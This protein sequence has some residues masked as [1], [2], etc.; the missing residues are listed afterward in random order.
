[1]NLPTKAVKQV[2]M[3]AAS[4][5]RVRLALSLSVVGK[6]NDI[7]AIH[8]IR[9]RHLLKECAGGDIGI[10]QHSAVSVIRC[11]VSG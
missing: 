4:L 10:A 5:I 3:G 9:I 7:T 2:L 1:M 11:L 6:Q 8:R